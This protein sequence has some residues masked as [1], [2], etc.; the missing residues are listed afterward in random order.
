MTPQNSTANRSNLAAIKGLTYV[1]FAMFAMTTDS[2]GIIILGGGLSL[3][4]EPLRAAVI[5]T[6]LEHPPVEFR[7]CVPFVRLAEFTAHEQQLFSGE[8]PLIGQ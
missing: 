7:V 8:Q 1:M 6:G 5:R 3:L 2:V 4:G